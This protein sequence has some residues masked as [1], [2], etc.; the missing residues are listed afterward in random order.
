MSRASSVSA[1]DKSNLGR[2]GKS[3]RQ[4]RD[5]SESFDSRSQYTPYYGHLQQ[6]TW[7]SQYMPPGNA[8]Y[9]EQYSQQYSQQ[10]QPPYPTPM[11]TGYGPP[12]QGYPQMIPNSGFAQYN[13]MTG[14]S[15]SWKGVDL[16][17]ANPVLS[18]PNL[19]PNKPPTHLLMGSLWVGMFRPCHLLRNSHGN[20]IMR[21][22]RC[23]TSRREVQH[24]SKARPTSARLEF[25]MPLANF[26]PT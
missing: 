1:K 11:S 7:T 8:Q 20:L 6:P 5:D 16:A 23:L 9:N 14:V 4:R 13:P 10:M 2:R 17:V 21:A 12:A 3:G 25:R 24:R 15:V 19:R 18:I 22:P 26:L